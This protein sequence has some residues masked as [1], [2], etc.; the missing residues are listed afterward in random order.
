M[1][2]FRS[3]LISLLLAL[4][5]Y[6]GDLI[7]INGFYVSVETNDWMHRRGEG[8]RLNVSVSVSRSAEN[9]NGSTSVEVHCFEFE[10]TQ[11]MLPDADLEAFMATGDAAQKGEAFRQTV[12]TKTFRG[13]KETTYEVV[14]VDG[15]KMIRMSRGEEKAEFMP[16]EATK[17]RA[18]LAEARAGQA[19]FK[20]LLAD[21][22]MPVPNEEARPPQTEGYYL[23]SAIGT[24]SGKGI[25]YEV[26]VASHSR[27][28][29]PQY[30]IKHTICL[31]SEEG[32]VNGTLSGDWVAGLLQKIASALEAVNAGNAYTFTSGEKDGRRY[33]VTANPNTKAADVILNPG[34]FFKNRKAEK[35]SF[36]QAQLA[37]IRKLIDGCD[38]RTKWFQANE[39]LF[40]T[41]THGDGG[42]AEGGNGDQAR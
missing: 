17:V 33:S 4:P 10:A 36:G 28:A 39:H 6:G 35:G 31:Y 3:L 19:W 20:K 18:A 5:S 25:G 24:V 22:T 32:K 15:K 16:A 21:K 13:E 7:P 9:P 42:H 29:A 40:F 11:R 30:R 37:D 14:E 8:A 12:M 38:E 27:T 23:D 2:T 26:S 1:K 34:D 41:S